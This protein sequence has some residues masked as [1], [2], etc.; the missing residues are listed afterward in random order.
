M[1]KRSKTLVLFDYDW[2]RIEFKKLS[3]KW[4]QCRAGFDLFSFPANLRFAWF[5]INRFSQLAALRAKLQGVKAVV[6]NHEQ[7]GALCAALVAEKLGLPGTSVEAVLA[8]QHKLHARE[9]LQR[10][11]PEAN[12]LSLMESIILSL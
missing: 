4:P 9:V 11:A 6:S 5:D 12:L 2:D 3:R 7:Y 1:T 10:V 8:C